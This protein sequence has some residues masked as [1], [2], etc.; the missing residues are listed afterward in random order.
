[1]GKKSKQKWQ[2]EQRQRIVD[3]YNQALARYGKESPQTNKFLRD[4]A[5]F[6]RA[7]R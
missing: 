1:M 3:K 6:D 2:Q 5:D 4:L 7:N